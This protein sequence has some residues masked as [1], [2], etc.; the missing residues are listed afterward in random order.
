MK[1]FLRDYDCLSVLHIFFKNS[2]SF[3]INDKCYYHCPPKLPNS[4]LTVC[5]TKHAC[6]IEPEAPP[7]E[8]TGS[9]VS[10]K[11][12]RVTWKPPD[13]KKQNGKLEGY[14]VFVLENI[15]GKTDKDAVEKIVGGDQ[16][17]VTVDGLKTWTEYKVSVL[18]F[19]KVGDGPRSAPVIVKTDEDGR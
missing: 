7:E 8:V 6:P 1:L 18:A 14:R 5:N 12:I 9:A 3:S 17:S 2:V 4:L 16:L 10:A 11:E 13:P 19:T 15:S